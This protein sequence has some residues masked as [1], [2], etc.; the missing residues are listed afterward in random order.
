MTTIAILGAGRVSANLATKLLEAGHR[1]TVGT[2]GGVDNWAGPPITLAG[3]EQAA[4]DSEIVVNATPGEGSVE[5]LA[6]LRDALDGK[7]LIDLTNAT[8]RDDEGRPSGLLYTDRSLAEHIQQA[9]PGTRVV[10]TLNTM[11]FSVMTAPGSLSSPLTAFLSGNDAEAKATV[12]G[13]LAD[14]GW[15]DEWIEDLGDI[16]TARGTE[17]LMLLVPSIVRNHGLK[18]FALTIS[19]VR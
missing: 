5:R 10:K 19:S 6:A 1:V 11:L 3:M 15:A 4:R 16:T 9:L 2:R 17:A 12:W 8:G 7:I 13:L 18:P 14:L